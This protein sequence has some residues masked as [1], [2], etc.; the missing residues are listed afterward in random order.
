MQGQD[1]VQVDAF[2]VSL[3]ARAVRVRG[4]PGSVRVSLELPEEDRAVVLLESGGVYAWRWPEASEAP[5]VSTRR[6]SPLLEPARRRW[7]FDLSTDTAGGGVAEVRKTR[8]PLTEFI[9][10][11]VRAFVL[12]FVARFAVQQ[13]VTFLERDTRRGLVL[14]EGADPSRWRFVADLGDVRLP[15]GRPT[16]ILLWVHGTFSTTKGSFGALG[17][18]EGGR[19]FLAAALRSYDL[20]IG[21]DH[22]TLAED[23]YENA[24]D[25]LARLECGGFDVAP[26]IDAVAFS[27]GA[28]VLRSLMEYL[29]PASRLGA[30]VRR[31]V[32]VGGTNGGTRLASPANWEKFVDLSTNLAV[33]AGRAVSFLGAPV[34]GLVLS[35]SISTLG[36]LV[37]YLV[38]AA[39]QERRVPGLNAMDPDGLFIQ[40]LNTEQPGQPKASESLC[41]VVSSDFEVVLGGA[42][43]P[44]LPERLKQWMLDTLAD[45]LFQEP[46]DLVVHTKAMYGI[47]A[48]V[49]D[50]VKDRLD[51]PR[52][53]HVY[54]TIYFTRP[55]VVGALARWF[56][57]GSP[58]FVTGAVRHLAPPEPMTAGA[59]PSV[60]FTDGGVKYGELLKDIHRQQ[61]DYVVVERHKGPTT[62]HHAFRSDELLS[63]DRPQAATV[64][65]KLAGLPLHEALGTTTMALHE[66]SASG[67]LDTGGPIPPPAPVDAPVTQRRV[68]L[69]D[70][71]TPWAVVE[72]ASALPSSLQLGNMERR[73][74]RGA[75]P[76]S[77]GG[78]PGNVRLPLATAELPLTYQVLTENLMA[79]PPPEWPTPA[80]AV[81]AFFVSASMPK[82][83]QVGHTAHVF[84]TVSRDA[85]ES[86]VEA[87]TAEAAAEVALDQ[88]LTVQL[89]A[90][91][92]LTLEGEVRVTLDPAKRRRFDLVFD[93]QGT[94]EGMGEL[95]ILIRQG[96][97]ALARLVLQPIISAT[98]TTGQ[99]SIAK[100]A[101]V[102]PSRGGRFP[103]LQIFE[104]SSGDVSGYHFALDL[105]DG[106]F[107]TG[108]SKPFK[109]DRGA[110]VAG[111]Y[112][113][114][115][116]A[117]I[118]H[119]DD[120]EAFEESLRAY[121][122]VLFDELV[123]APLQQALWRVRDTLGAIQV[124]SEE[125]FI[126]WEIVHLKPPTEGT[127]GPGPLPPEVHFL[128]QKGLVRWLHDRGPAARELLVREGR[129][130]HVVPVYPAGQ[131]ELP[132]AQREVPFLEKRLG[133]RPVEAE[134]STL[135]KLLSSAGTV[136]L[137]HFAGHGVAEA[138]SRGTEA[139]RTQL[140]LQGR[141]EQGQYVPL[142]L[143]AML[144]QQYARLIGPDGHQ[145][146]IV[147]NACQVGRANWQLTSMG[148]FAEAFIRAGAGAF[149]GPLWSVGD[150]LARTFMTA[151]Y[152]ALLQGE[153]LA[154]AAGLGREAARKAGDAT[155]LAYAVYGH[156]EANLRRETEAVRKGKAGAA[157]KTAT[158]RGGVRP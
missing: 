144:V 61:P 39:T 72:P 25:L 97:E 50:F 114:I 147:L 1:F 112:T 18:S 43:A 136:D 64:R 14:M 11:R 27:R 57:L 58:D 130:H 66:E 20:V 74:V 22:S 99:G 132:E 75:L 40:Q 141:V 30:R 111:I 154:R 32:F 95:W 133:A 152:E 33:A 86:A 26:R 126:P 37:K 115:E 149:V 108:D 24:V 76:E 157:K 128:A 103:V 121:G 19:A 110:Y 45:S 13:A 80:P 131:Y 120:V 31:A 36:S 118:S 16:R 62:Y 153:P 150:G 56:E 73:V 51:I 67:R 69:F 89:V 28:L 106:G 21:Y 46:N 52:N 3:P 54:H 146:L 10:G 71:G 35:E 49:G 155:W 137:F 124:V 59:D 142:Y 93:L 8:G 113:A 42:G 81:A 107:V 148:G 2:D 9:G 105:G 17:A 127:G 83:V 119:K 79:S 135:R 123:P 90:K 116:D 138:Q 134:V 34:A 82:A 68:I 48:S 98:S 87:L 151:F 129:A 109:G 140:M 158:K 55:E 101:E 15:R 88:K 143:D 53:P 23:P 41:F 38:V 44:E 156:P 63:L 47:D 60:L 77:P 6:S 100:V 7:V 65:A 139:P 91:T 85:I 96:A 125:P 122:G 84:V 5:V 70:E 4:E 104:T 78:L 29:L 92:N 12:K 117:W 94:H 102:L 145:P